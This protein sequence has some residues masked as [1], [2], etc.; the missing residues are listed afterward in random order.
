MKTQHTQFA[1]SL[2][3]IALALLTAHWVSLWPMLGA[4]PFWSASATYLGLGLGA[5]I[6]TVS[7]LILSRHPRWRKLHLGIFVSL[8]II[9]ITASTYGKIDFVASFADDRFAGRVWY[10]GFIFFIAGI[11]GSFTTAVR[12][13]RGSTT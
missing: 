6:A 10:Y 11:P 4:H 9:G 12:L 7:H 5:L 13:L 3:A 2:F 1:I 8:T